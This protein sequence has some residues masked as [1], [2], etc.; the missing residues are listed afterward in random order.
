M[1]LLQDIHAEDIK[2]PSFDRPERTDPAISGGSRVILSYRG[3]ELFARVTGIER[4][5]SSFVG[6]L[7]RLAQPEVGHEDLAVGDVIRFRLK[8]VHRTD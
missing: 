3:R 7:L 6:H 8:D 5:G 1:S 2:E 4:L